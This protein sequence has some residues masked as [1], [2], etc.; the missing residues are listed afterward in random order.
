MGVI[1]NSEVGLTVNVI[2]CG[3]VGYPLALL[4]AAAGHDVLAVDI[5]PEVIRS[6]NDARPVTD[7]PGL[8]D[9]LEVA[10]SSQKLR[11]AASPEVS[12]VFVICVPT[13]VAEDGRTPDLSMVAAAAHS[14]AP[15]LRSGAMVIVESTVPPGTC[16]ALVAP[17]LEEGGLRVGADFFLA[18]C[19][20][21]ILPGRTLEEL[22]TGERVIG[23]IDADSAEAARR[24]YR[25]FSKGELIETNLETA[26][27]C[28]LMENTFRD[29]NI[30]LANQIAELADRHGVD[31][32]EAIRIAN[33]H[34]RVNYLIPGIG[35]GGHCIPVDPWFLVGGEDDGALI[36]TARLVNDRRPGRVAEVLMTLIAGVD[37]PRV[38][39]AGASYKPNVSDIRNSPALTIRDRLQEAGADVVV[40]DPLVPEFAG[41]LA[42]M[43]AG[44][45]LMAILVPHSVV[46]AE[47]F[48]MRAVLEDVMRQAIVVDVSSGVPRELDR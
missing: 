9:L 42:E 19:P 7:E 30:A 41:D 26:E 23:G 13:P 36:V 11:G 8:G 25:T 37:G 27:F 45:D 1:R 29:V 35:V 44:A 38:V 14:V 10:R 4:A 6:I 5:N 24:F 15:R 21:R 12:D 47:I 33:G 46:L 32:L 3:Y 31:P 40:Y 17:I 28:K 34:P 18:H 48:R 43:S 20:E 2:G 39:L 22:T 16:R